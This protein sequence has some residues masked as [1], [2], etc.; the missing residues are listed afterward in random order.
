MKTLCRL[1][2][3]PLL[4][5]C[6]LS[7][8][9][10]TARL[11]QL[12]TAQKAAIDKTNTPAAPRPQRVAMQL[13]DIIRQHD[14]F[15][16]GEIEDVPGLT[17]AKS[18]VAALLNAH[19]D[20]EADVSEFM[21]QNKGP[22][23][24]QASS[25]IR[26]GKDPEYYVELQN[27]ME[28]LENDYQLIL[29]NF[30][31]IGCFQNED[32]PIGIDALL[33]DPVNGAIPNK[34][35]ESNPYSLCD[36]DLADQLFQPLGDVNAHGTEVFDHFNQKVYQPL[37]YKVYPNRFS[38]ADA[39]QDMLNLDKDNLMIHADMPIPDQTKFKQMILG[40]FAEIANYASDFD[41]NK[42]LISK[43][44]LDILKHFHIYWNVKRQ[45]NQV[46]STKVNTF[47]I[48]Q[49]IVKRYREQNEAMKATTVHIL[50][51]IRDAY[52]RFM[53][54][55][56]ML[57]LMQSRSADVLTYNILKRYDSYVQ[58]VLQG[59][60]YRDTHVYE[61]S[62]FMEYFVT[63]IGLS[64]SAGIKN[65][66]AFQIFQDQVYVKII[67]MYNVYSKW[68]LET[69][70]PYFDRVTEC[71]ASILLK[72]KQ[73]EAI[74][75]SLTSPQGFAQLPEFTFRSR[76]SSYIK[77]F[78][79]IMDYWIL[80]PLQ[81]QNLVRLDKCMTG[82]GFEMLF[83]LRIKNGLN[84]AAA[85]MN[86][87]RYLSNSYDQMFDA[88]S[89]R[90]GFASYDSFR[91]MYFAELFK[92]FE[93]ARLLYRLND[94]SALDRLQNRL[95][96]NIEKEKTAKDLE[97]PVL[98]ML[99]KLDDQMYD[100]FLDMRDNYNSFGKMGMNAAVLDEISSRFEEFIDTFSQENT[101]AKDPSIVTLFK[102]LKD[103]MKEWV[104]SLEHDFVKG[105]EDEVAWTPGSQYTVLPARDSVIVENI[106]KEPQIDSG[107]SSPMF[108]GQ[109]SQPAANQ[110]PRKV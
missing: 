78:Y 109:P 105:L 54:A 39:L 97:K 24:L 100:F 32:R 36:G 34:T 64:N 59:K 82:M 73:R 42:P 91:N 95:G 49:A 6:V 106:V 79:E 93:N 90:N 11:S 53:R 98:D 99:I 23:D 48:L 25:S 74:L 65:V 9:P 45:A 38:F 30:K 83:K 15:N 16:T 86:L 94:M 2:A 10:E 110:M 21:R 63:H 70:S 75:F 80:V 7:L 107:L 67:D 27:Q 55:H 31:K 22:M 26:V 33:L 13:D 17:S 52:F 29:E 77:T 37:S 104:S 12:I 89:A 103:I 87:Y 14:K 72:L 50:N 44:V 35:T 85:G 58:S 47:A 92:M 71:T 108:V 28:P 41:A 62:V 43:L 88:I 96:K 51:S 40:G 19:A 61:L 84:L 66:D 101:M 3:I 20:D 102:V 69:N 46:D 68:M 18:K 56:K 5:A 8:A 60:F 1:S 4:L 57:S 76:K 81:C